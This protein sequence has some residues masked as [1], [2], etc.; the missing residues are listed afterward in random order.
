MFPNYISVEIRETSQDQKGREMH[1]QRLRLR[2]EIGCIPGRPL[3]GIS[4]CRNLKSEKTLL[5]S[6]SEWLKRTEMPSTH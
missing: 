2:G 6:D 4:K 3:L 5:L 1:R